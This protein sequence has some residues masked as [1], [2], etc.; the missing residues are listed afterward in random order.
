MITQ[1]KWKLK[2][3][4]VG[5]S[6]TTVG[7]RMKQEDLYFVNETSIVLCDGHVDTDVVSYVGRHFVSVIDTKSLEQYASNIMKLDAEMQTNNNMKGGCTCVA[8]TF[9][10]K[11][12]GKKHSM[13]W[14]NVS[15]LIHDY[16]TLPKSS[17]L[18]TIA[19]IGDSQLLVYSNQKIIFATEPHRP[20]SV[21][22]K[23]RIEKAG[24]TVQMDS[25]GQYRIADQSTLKFNLS[26]TFGNFSE[27]R[28][29]NLSVF[30]QPMIAAPDI[31]QIWIP[32]GS[33]IVMFSDGMTEQ[34]SIPDI[35]AILQYVEDYSV[36]QIARILLEMAYYRN[37]TD[38]ITICVVKIPGV[39]EVPDFFSV[40]EIPS[41]IESDLD[42]LIYQDKSLVHIP[43]DAHQWI[44]INADCYPE[45]VDVIDFD[46]LLTQIDEY[47]TKSKKIIKEQQEKKCILYD[48]S[49]SCETKPFVFYKHEQDACTQ[50]WLQE[51]NRFLPYGLYYH[52]LLVFIL[53]QKIS[54]IEQKEE[55]LK[56]FGNTEFVWQ[57]TDKKKNYGQ[58]SNEHQTLFVLGLELTKEDEKWLHDEKDW[59]TDDFFNEIIARKKLV[60]DFG[61]IVYEQ[62][63]NI[64]LQCSGNV[65]YSIYGD[66]ANV[67]WISYEC[68]KDSLHKEIIPLV[69]GGCIVMSLSPTTNYSYSSAWENKTLL[70]RAL[71]NHLNYAVSLALSLSSHTIHIHSIIMFAQQYEHY[72]EIIQKL[73]KKYHLSTSSPSPFIIYF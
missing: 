69:P 29:S 55:E 32:P 49:F 35:L 37:S 4:V 58:V 71:N 42:T 36:E 15:S 48:P 40:K 63:R 43:S 25:N 9:E 11:K 59:T 45:I 17:L 23:K 60:K 22:E 50:T 56:R 18:A 7:R 28:I 65:S 16:P 20:F 67:V 21:S 13:C 38:N 34:L 41:D 47:I 30:E 31:T 33:L 24:L 6:A 19:N 53:L 62:D 5:A 61:M 27:K 14:N 46:L 10:E 66:H 44:I 26:R 57:T 3:G 39:K 51:L 73:S 12:E 1:H 72:L 54:K 68:K 70:H 52:Q 8:I 2:F 64:H